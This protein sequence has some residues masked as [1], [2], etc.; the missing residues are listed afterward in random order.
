[1]SDTEKFSAYVANFGATLSEQESE[2]IHELV[3]AA[4]ARG[5]HSGAHSVPLACIDVKVV[6]TLY[7]YAASEN[8]NAARLRQMVD[9]LGIPP[10]AWAR[11]AIF[12]ILPEDSAVAAALVI[13]LWK[14]TGGERFPMVLRR[15]RWVEMGTP[16]YALENIPLQGFF[17]GNSGS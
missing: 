10:Q 11:R 16:V 2:R 8:F 5:L 7:T 14:R 6:S 9:T 17:E 3:M 15:R 13:E 4:L 12:V 1:M